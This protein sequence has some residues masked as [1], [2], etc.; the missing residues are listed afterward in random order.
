[1]VFLKKQIPLD[2]DKELLRVNPVQLIQ[3]MK[4][5]FNYVIKAKI[6]TEEILD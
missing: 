4:I 1:M 2:D 6:D 5:I 3:N